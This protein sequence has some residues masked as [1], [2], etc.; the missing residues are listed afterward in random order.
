MHQSDLIFY[1]E[2]D[3]LDERIAKSLSN[4]MPLFLKCSGREQAVIIDF[5]EN[6]YTDKEVYVHPDLDADFDIVNMIAANTALV[7]A[8]QKTHYFES[9]KWLYLCKGDLSGIDGDA[10]GHTT[11]RLDCDIAREEISRITPGNNI[12]IHEFTHVLDNLLG[13]SGSHP[14]LR[15]SY[16]DY[17]DNL[18]SGKELVFSGAVHFPRDGYMSVIRA[19]AAAQGHS[20][21]EFLAYGAEVFFTIPDLLKEHYP[22]FF[23]FFIDIF[24]LDFSGKGINNIP[25]PDYLSKRLK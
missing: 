16:S 24:G 7:G 9:V 20:E 1:K 15:Q 6:F 18:D 8:A 25:L 21:I 17:V 11:V 13:I 5:V 10:R 2:T 19:G 3:G 4:N 12:V 23:E 22:L 14:R